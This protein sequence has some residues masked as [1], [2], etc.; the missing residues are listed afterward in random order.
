MA[1][2]ET[3]VRA[4]VAKRIGAGFDDVTV[5]CWIPDAKGWPVPTFSVPE[6]N[7][8][9][10]TALGLNVVARMVQS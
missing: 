10:V 1:P 6:S 5:V 7:R 8:A 9:Q 4:A 3:R 2:L